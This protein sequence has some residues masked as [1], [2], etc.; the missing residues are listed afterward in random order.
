MIYIHKVKCK[1]CGI[2]FDRDKE[3]FK[4]ISERRFAHLKC[5]IAAENEKSQAEKDKEDLEKYIMKNI[6][7]LI[8]V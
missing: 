5:A 1:Y 7:S 4:Q 6:I 3:P 2:V 8:L